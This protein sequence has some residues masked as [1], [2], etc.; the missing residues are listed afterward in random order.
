[1]AKQTENRTEA[2]DQLWSQLDKTRVSMLWVPGTD[3]HPQPM[4]H[5][6]NPDANAIWFITSSDTDL[7][8]AVGS[9]ASGRLVL[10][11][12]SQDYHA[13]LFGELTF[14]RDDAKLDS[15]WSTPAA[16][17]FEKGRED[18]T[19]RLLKFTPDEASIWASQ[20]NSVLVGL[21]LLRAG[22]QEDQS[23]PDVGV[24]HILNMSVAA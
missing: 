22:M 3:Q 12:K 16:A 21:K 15:L 11:G 18:P 4:T 10:V 1:M 6:A 23:E 2:I 19:V 7:A 5:F 13:S 24:H 8:V 9:G 17:W 20:S 14:S